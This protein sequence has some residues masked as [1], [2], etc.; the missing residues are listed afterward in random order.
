MAAERCVVETNL[1]VYSTVAGNPWHEEARAW[2]TSL[3]DG[4]KTLC[5]TTQILREYLVVLTAGRA[6]KRRFSV[7]EALLELNAILETVDLFGESPESTSIHRD[8]LRRN[9]VQ[10]KRIH[11]ANV[12]AVMLTNGVSLLATYN[13]TDFAVFEELQLVPLPSA[14]RRC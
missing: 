7:A 13:Q 2:L 4:R 10:G 11:D 14:S 12:V 5:I 6:F 9:D 3:V 8:L 1:L